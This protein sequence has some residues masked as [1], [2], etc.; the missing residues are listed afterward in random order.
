MLRL[1]KES[2]ASY[3]YYILYGCVAQLTERLKDKISKA[4]FLEQM[5]IAHR[6]EKFA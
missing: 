2:G 6:A 4:A 3:F 1:Q 5:K